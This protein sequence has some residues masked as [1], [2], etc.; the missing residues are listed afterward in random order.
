MDARPILEQIVR[1]LSECRLDAV[2][3]GNAAAALQGA[4]VTTL[5]FDFMYRES[6]T[7]VTKIKGFARW[8]DAVVFKPYYPASHLY[9]VVNEDR[10]IQVDFMPRIDGVRSYR[11][12]RSR[13]AALDFSGY[14]L[15]VASLA[16]VIASKKAAGRSRDRAVLGILMETLREKK[17]I[18]IRPPQGPRQEG[19]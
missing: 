8:M 19:K 5:D 14:T 3:V 6:R 1:G 17:S 16:D 9:R 12:L 4:P 7:N 13:A 15:L 11:G 18:P 10:G 2:L